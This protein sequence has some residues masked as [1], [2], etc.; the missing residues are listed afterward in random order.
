ML[1][2]QINTTRQLAGSEEKMFECNSRQLV[3]ILI[4]LNRQACNELICNNDL[5]LAR[6]NAVVLEALAH[7]FSLDLK[8]ATRVLEV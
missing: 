8:P 2:K 3:V 6:E 4:K 5:A 1:E 7:L